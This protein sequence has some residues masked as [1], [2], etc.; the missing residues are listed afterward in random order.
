[1]LFLVSSRLYFL[2]K[3]SFFQIFGE[4]M[5]H[6]FETAL[7]KEF[8]EEDRAAWMTFYHWIGGCIVKGMSI[9]AAKT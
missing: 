9:E 1:M 8:T 3:C 6:A 4:C 2:K 5:I 7:G